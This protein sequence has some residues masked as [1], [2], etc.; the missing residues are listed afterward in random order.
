MILSEICDKVSYQ[1]RCRAADQNQLICRA[2]SFMLFIRRLHEIMDKERMAGLNKKTRKKIKNPHT[3][4]NKNIK[5]LM[6]VI[7]M[8]IGATSM[9]LGAAVAGRVEGEDPE[10]IIV[11][12]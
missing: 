10:W 4:V 9:Y 6:D 7:L 3:P 2:V 12:K 1:K 8:V 11:H 5:F